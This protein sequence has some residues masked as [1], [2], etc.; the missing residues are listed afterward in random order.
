ML[1]EPEDKNRNELVQNLEQTNPN[2]TSIGKNSSSMQ[3]EDVITLTSGK[4]HYLCNKCKSFHLI[5]IDEG[6]IVID[7]NKNEKIKLGQFLLNNILNIEN[8]EIFKLCLIHKSEK[9]GFCSKCK[10]D[11]CQ[12]CKEVK[13]CENNKSHNFLDFKTKNE[14]ISKKEKFILSALKKKD[15]QP[16][17][18]NSSNPGTL[19]ISEKTKFIKVDEKEIKILEKK[20]VTE[21]LEELS[22]IPLFMKTLMNSKENIPSYIHYENI[23][24]LYH[25]FCD[26][27]KLYYYSYSNNQ[28]RIR[29][30]GDQFIKNNINNCSVMINNELKK[31]EDCEFYELED[32]EE[33]LSITL[34]KEDD[35]IDMSYMFNDCEV[36]QSISEES[37]WST[38]NV[39][40]MSY[41]FC[42][43]K[44]LISLPTIISGW[45][46]SKVTDMSNMFSGCESLSEIKN[47]SKW[48]TSKVENMH[49]MFYECNFLENLENIMIWDTK[50]VTNMSYMFY[51]C[52]A[53]KNIDIENKKDNQA[54]WN[55]EKVDNISYMF[56]GCESLERLPDNFSFLKTG[57]VKHMMYMFYNCKSLKSL[58]DISKWE[59]G[60][61]IYMNNLFE[62]CS[63]LKSLKDISKWKIDSL[64][65]IDF[66]IEGCT[67]LDNPLNLFEW[68]KIK[69]KKGKLLET[70]LKIK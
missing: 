31:I 63:S 36:L 48:D 66:L 64:I 21:C 24:I 39:I 67:S 42:N 37:K 43:C 25:F 33:G 17:I 8:L 20:S 6:K 11:L 3:S 15:I 57:K 1:E 41:M 65:S 56:Y 45:D 53:L 22:D 50:N 70:Y 2:S 46:T 58:P 18:E 23:N 4:K 61:V 19:N 32:I 7:C 54:K 14:K 59:T 29:L 13:D 16:K 26:K 52:L 44:A 51:N 12:K 49:K 47:I 35:I 28:T 68:N 34:L 10:K 40:N 60:N 38:D 69:Y 62:N 5:K 30:F 9:I 27:L 55:T